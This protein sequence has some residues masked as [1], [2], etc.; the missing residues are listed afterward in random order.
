M[1]TTDSKQLSQNSVTV[2]NN[3]SAWAKISENAVA[4]NKVGK[5]SSFKMSH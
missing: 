3:R 2:K 1:Q 4:F 5:L